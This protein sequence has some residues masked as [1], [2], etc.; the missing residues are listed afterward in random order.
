MQGLDNKVI[1]ITGASR[2]IGAACVNSCLEAGATVLANCRNAQSAEKLSLIISEKFSKRFHSLIYDVTDSEALKQ[3]FKF[4]QSQF[5]R[6]DGLVN[7]AGVMQEQALAMTRK[8]DLEAMFAVNVS[9]AF[10]HIQFASRLMMRNKQGSIVNLG[11]IVGEYGGKGQAAYA[12]SKASLSVL[13]K[14]AAKELGPSGIR[15]NTVAPGFIETDLTAHYS[16]AKKQEIMA[17]VPLGRLGLDS[18]VANVI[19]FL[20]SDDAQYVSGQVIGVDGALS[21]P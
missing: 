11:S 18:D 4:I 2:G 16:E 9:A 13:S 12:M 7:N 14:S 8:I 19:R 10:E 5:G 21:F 17:N 6:L 1:L 3:Q 20:L 15:V